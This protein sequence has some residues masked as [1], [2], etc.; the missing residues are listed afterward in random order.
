MII[1]LD[2]ALLE[3][4]KKFRSVWHQPTEKLKNFLSRTLNR[5][6][7]I[8]TDR[9]YRQKNYFFIFS[10]GIWN[11][12]V[13][14]ASTGKFLFLVVME[15]GYSLYRYTTTSL[16]HSKSPCEWRNITHMRSVYNNSANAELCMHI[17]SIIYYIMHDYDCNIKQHLYLCNKL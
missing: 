14:F 13:G 11:F 5:Q 3:T 1:F 16:T 10:V 6:G 17:E 7:N 2:N 8:E 15:L 4:K 9:V 12:S